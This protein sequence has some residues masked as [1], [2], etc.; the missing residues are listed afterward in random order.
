M[1][2]AAQL[3]GGRYLFLTD[4]S[5]VGFVHAEPHIPCYSVTRLDHAVVRMIETELTGRRIASE[6]E[7]ILRR[8]GAPNVD[9]TCTVGEMQV[10]AF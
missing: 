5:H 9:G 10:V 4:D 6:P 1:R 8:A 3:T 2:A 7:Q